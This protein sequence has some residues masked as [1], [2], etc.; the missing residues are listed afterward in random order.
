MPLEGFLS[1][2]ALLITGVALGLTLVSLLVQ[3]GATAKKQVLA[4]DSPAFK[5]KRKEKAD[6]DVWT[7]DMGY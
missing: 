1:G 4:D 5:P 2:N 6:P 3:F 7:G